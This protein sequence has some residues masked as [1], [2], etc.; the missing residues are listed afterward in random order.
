[1]QVLY[2]YRAEGRIV[3]ANDL[4]R[5]PPPLRASAERVDLSRVSLNLEVGRGLRLETERELERLR[6]ADARRQ[7]GVVACDDGSGVLAWLG[8]GWRE[9]G[10]LLAIAGLLLALALASPYLIRQLTP[11]RWARLVT[12]VVPLLLA[13][14]LA[15]VSAART[16]RVAKGLRTHCPG[17]EPAG[18]APPSTPTPAGP[19]LRKLDTRLRAVDRETPKTKHRAGSWVRP[20]EASGWV[21]APKR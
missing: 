18:D 14:A 16:S 7:A 1:M 2:R 20:D 9:H 15:T 11:E 8:R 13:L 17:V 3:Y 21:G 4:E 19:G 5:I 6:E 12:F 10:H